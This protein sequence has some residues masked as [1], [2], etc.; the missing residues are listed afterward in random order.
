MRYIPAVEELDCVQE[1]N[2]AGYSHMMRFREVTFVSDC[3]PRTVNSIKILTFWP[4]CHS[5]L[6]FSHETQRRRLAELFSV[7]RKHHKTLSARDP[8]EMNAL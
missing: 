1:S 6:T 8:E 3:A 4:W 2:T 7:Q 5:R